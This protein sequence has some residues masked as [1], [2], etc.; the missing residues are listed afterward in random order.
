MGRLRADEGLRGDGE[1]SEP[2]RA[3]L[4]RDR[5]VA[6]AR[7]DDCLPERRLPR[8]AAVHGI[9][10]LVLARA[11]TGDGLSSGQEERAGRRGAGRP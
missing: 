10:D 7:V 1:D 2:R 5:R 9:A 8:R 4:A 6:E 11:V 3:L